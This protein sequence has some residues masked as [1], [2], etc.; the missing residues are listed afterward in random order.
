MRCI[1]LKRVCELDFD[2]DA[3]VGVVVVVLVDDI[4]VVVIVADELEAD[5]TVNDD[6]VI[7]VVVVDGIAVSE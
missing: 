3:V 5:V 1:L 4:N 7:V 6:A 2:N